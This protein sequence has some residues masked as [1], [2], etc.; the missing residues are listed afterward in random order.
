ME[1]RTTTGQ[2]EANDA[3][4]DPR[5]T[6]PPLIRAQPPVLPTG[7]G[8]MRGIGEK[9][10]T[11]AANG[12]GSL[13]V[14]LPLTRAR[15]VQPEL[16]LHYD[17]G[18]GNGPFGAG[19]RLSPPC[20]TR[21]TDKQLPTYLDADERDTFVMSG[22]EDLVPAAGG[23]P[24][25]RRYRPRVEGGFVRIEH[26]LEA[27]A[28]WS[29]TTAGNV[30]N[31]YGRSSNA[32]IADPDDPRRVFSWLLE[33]TEDA[34][35]NV[36][37]FEYVAEDLANVVRGPAEQHRLD[38]TAKI[39]NR[40]LKR[41]RYGN[42][43]PGDDATCVF[44]VVFDYGDHAED[45]PVATPGLWPVRADAFSTYRAGF[46]QRTYRL[47]RRV[48]MFHAFPEL[49]PNPC[50]VRS[51]A[52]TYDGDPALAHLVEIEQRGHA[53]TGDHYETV[54]IPALKL[55]YTKPAPSTT[56]EVAF[57]GA[58]DLAGGVDGKR[59]QWVDL[60]AEG[61][62]G[63]L[64]DVGGGLYY[65]RNLGAGVLGPPR[66]LVTR[67]SLAALATGSQQLMDVGGDGRLDLVDL[68]PPLPGFFERT[69]GA[70]G[71]G[72][73]EAFQPFPSHPELAWTDPN[74]K[75]I[76]LDGDGRDDVLITNDDTFVWYPSLGKDGFGP[77]RTLPRP[78]DEDTGPAVVFAEV[79]HS[80]VLADLGGD[81]LRDLVRVEN[82]RICYWPNLG[83]GRFGAKV[84]MA[85]APVFDQ[86]DQ[87]EARRVLFADIDGSGASDVLYAHRDGV[88]YWLNQAG[89]A[90]SA[91]QDVAGL[92]P[93]TT[94]A[95]VTA[96]DVL[97]TGTA[98][99]V[100]SSSAPADAA[101]RYVDLVGGVKPHL[102]EEVDNQLGLVTRVR[103]APS[104]K[105]YLEDRIAGVH[106]AT[107]LGFP[108]HVIERVEVDDAIRRV[109]FVSE[110]RYRDGYFDG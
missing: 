52:F 30:R 100:W 33:R 31:I 46:E 8:A 39:A 41:I 60:D 38:G 75:F 110:Y 2:R 67:P 84:T 96:A 63:V 45:T 9:F 76:D 95:S 49:A 109:R 40:Y 108:V 99:V 58:G 7:G 92:P 53:W 26:H 15:G 78:R 56:G 32:R 16:A 10:S 47:C 13:V 103:Y 74:V 43:V 98:C 82:G 72:D 55:A 83:N 71:E 104:T 61:I 4:S 27:D 48:M 69:P 107:Q 18:S 57:D 66:A 34:F 6:A 25:V 50:L 80:I 73:W 94:A 24:G 21:K 42:T 35:G 90:W 36:T 11:N 91:A 88:R 37:V 87:F 44:E 65:R 62:P 19:W 22:A 5:G 106:W 85:N 102:L 59:H 1:E 89:N 17:S 86:P 64:S 79:T 81:G 93:D 51:V 14:P 101:L 28:W 12:T 54:A 77:P 68:G 105:F 97:G 29:S 70:N 20:I 23:P 3:S